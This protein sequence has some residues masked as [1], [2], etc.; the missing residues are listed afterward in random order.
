M[1]KEVKGTLFVDYVRMV[2]SRKDVDWSKYLNEEDMKFLGQHTRI[3]ASNWYPFDTF[4]RMGIGV[5]HEIGGGDPEVI[6]RWGQA[7]VDLM[8][9]VYKQLVEPG[10]PIRSAENFNL[11]RAGFFNFPGVELE[12]F[13]DD[14]LIKLYVFFSKNEQAAEAQAYQAFGAI[15][16]LIDLAGAKNIKYE[17]VARVW[18]GD[19]KTII[20]ITWD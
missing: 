14:K 11:F 12:L 4:E 16:R 15:E 20:E 9:K 19:P 2:R 13:P 5:F 6:R 8:V 10:D 7:S 17:F 3:L 1:A 18:D